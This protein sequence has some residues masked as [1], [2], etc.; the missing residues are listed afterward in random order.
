[1]N[2]R[3][4]LT[5]V[6]VGWLSSSMPVAIAAILPDPDNAPAF[7]GEAE[8]N[9]MVQ[10][11]TQFITVGTVAKLNQDG[12]IVNPNSAIGSILIVRDP[13]KPNTL[14][15]VNPKCTHLGCPVEWQADRK[16][17]YCEC[18]DSRFGATGKALSGPAKQP[19][20]VYEAKIQGNAVVARRKPKP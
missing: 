2:R 6:G 19:L 11:P 18:H 13:A 8:P 10:A 17:F 20:P 15:A 7:E 1:M 14:I 5:W 4:F 3:T 16:N 12:K 9:W